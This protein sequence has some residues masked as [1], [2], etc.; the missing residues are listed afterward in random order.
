MWE[1]RTIARSPAVRS[2]I[3]DGDEVQRPV[4]VAGSQSEVPGADRRDEA[5]VEGLGDVE[6]R[7]EAIPA[8]PEGELMGTELA[9][10]EQTEQSDAAEVRLEELEVLILVVLAQMPGVV[11]LF[12][13]GRREGEAVWCRDVRGPRE[14]RDPFEEAPGLL[15]VLDGLEKDDGV[16]LLVEFLDQV[17]PK[18]QIRPAIASAGMLVRLGVRVH[19]DHLGGS[20]GEQV[21]AVALAARQVRYPEAGA[22]FGNPLVDGDVAAI[23]VVL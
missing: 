4:E 6:R 14:P 23:P 22:A 21:R 11:G 10:M 12:G 13:A 7:V 20:P 5:V 9:R 2:A 19:A 17:A 3:T 15:D 1:C 18:A 16:N 8:E